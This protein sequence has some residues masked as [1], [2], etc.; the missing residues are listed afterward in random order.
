[1]PNRRRAAGRA[2]AAALAV[3]LAAPPAFAAQVVDVRIGRHPGFVR[4]V[5]ETDAPA[6]FV[7]EGDPAGGEVTV[8]LEAAS[9]SRRVGFPGESGPLVVVEPLPDGRS[10]AHI[11]TDQPVRV[12]TQ[13]LGAPPRVVLDLRAGEVGGE[14]GAAPEAEEAAR[15]AE[16]ATPGA[17]EAAADAEEAEAAA[18][19]PVGEPPVEVP[20]APGEAPTETLARPEL[21]PEL[22]EPEPVETAAL[23]GESEEPRPPLSPPAA[24]P[25]PEGLEEPAP[26]PP[27]VA[28]PPPAVPPPAAPPPPEPEIP[29]PPAARATSPPLAPARPPLEP[30]PP[31]PP[32]TR[33]LPLAWS[34]DPIS[35]AVGAILGV[36]L[37]GLAA[38][39]WWRRARAAAPV[40]I[41]TP[42]RVHEP[43]APQV[44]ERL[45]VQERE[46]REEIPGPVSTIAAPAVIEPEPAEAP[47]SPPAP[48]PEARPEV[49]DAELTSDLI[50][51]FQGLDRRF[52]R[53]ETLFERM[54]EQVDR[55]DARSAA[56][57]EELLAHRA[58]LA[59]LQHLA[60]RGPPARAPARTASH[61]AGS[62]SA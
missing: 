8:R 33:D 49:A 37:A 57:A 45:H 22:F 51:M 59:R 58:T 32:A 34:A 61:A 35:F 18:L 26:P 20:P 28:A 39:L 13:V 31:T 27:A 19:P 15:E 25:M 53:I 48:E 9:R 41:P 3:A 17:G 55:L 4:V 29:E 52:A 23:P 47:P 38:R 60:R 10:V 30:E 5:F 14:I 44:P 11:R 40:G 6:E 21:P 24:T 62:S 1:M 46:A 7:L 42:R 36:V 50:R 12:E 2:A 54:R 43:P 16:E 56:Q